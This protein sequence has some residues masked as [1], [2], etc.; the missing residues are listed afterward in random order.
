MRAHLF[1]N[2]SSTEDMHSAHRHLISICGMNKVKHWKASIRHWEVIQNTYQNTSDNYYLVTS[3]RQV[4]THSVAYNFKAMG[5][6]H[7]LSLLQLLLVN[8]NWVFPSFF[9]MCKGYSR[10]VISLYFLFQL[11]TTNFLSRSPSQSL[12]T[13]E[14]IG[15]A[16]HIPI[17]STSIRWSSAS[18]WPRNVLASF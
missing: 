17:Q 6:R 9:S 2:K 16:S 3:S 15:L 14:F 8:N 1:I 5:L 18:R 4:Y 11:P 13:Q 7:T 10:L 12:Q